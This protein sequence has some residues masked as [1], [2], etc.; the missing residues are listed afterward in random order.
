MTDDH[1]TQ[2]A[3]DEA[4][5]AVVER[6]G[7]WQDGAEKDTVAEELRK[8]FDEAEVAVPETDV[9]RLAEQIHADGTAD[10]EGVQAD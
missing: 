5:D 7:S 4:V 1:E 3:K 10:T 9:D 6:V 2:V 8:G